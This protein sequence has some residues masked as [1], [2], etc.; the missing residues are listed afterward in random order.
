MN[1][2]A[3]HGSSADFDSFDNE[4]AFGTLHWFT[5]QKDL[6]K[7]GEVGAGT[8]GFIY[9]VLLDIKNPAGWDEYDR[10]GIEELIG[11]GYDGL[12]LP[13]GPQTTFV[14]FSDDQ[15]QIIDKEKMIDEEK[16]DS[17]QLP[18]LNV[19]DELMVGKFKNR[20][21]TIKGFDTEKKTGQPIAKTDKGPQQIFKGRVKKLMPEDLDESLEKAY[22]YEWNTQDASDWFGDF[23]TQSGKKVA[24]S[25][26]IYEYASGTWIVNFDTDNSMSKTG[27]GDQFRIFATVIA[28]IKEFVLEIQPKEVMFV[29]EKDP[30]PKGRTNSRIDL[31]NSFLNRFAKDLGYSFEKQNNGYKITFRMH[32]NEKLDEDINAIE[33]ENIVKPI[34]RR[35]LS[36]R[37]SWETPGSMTGELRK[38]LG[39]IVKNYLRELGIKKT[40]TLIE[41][42]LSTKENMT[43][44]MI[45]NHDYK[46]AM[47]TLNIPR[48]QWKAVKDEKNSFDLWEDLV[49]DIQQIAVHELM[50][51][52]QWVMSKGKMANRTGFLGKRDYENDDKAVYLSD[53]HEISPFAANAV[54][55][56]IHK[57]F[58][59][60][61]IADRINEKEIHYLLANQSSTFNSFFQLFRKNKDSHEHQMVYK[62]FLKKFLQ[63]LNDRL[64]VEQKKLERAKRKG[65]VHP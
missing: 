4:F 53:K 14:A 56:L 30:K 61:K 6:I 13:D 57:D 65:W 60:S 41:I 32:K 49:E 47:F 27:D 20:K 29:A 52:N 2:R 59:L 18:K 19:G 25:I 50:H 35:L 46:R 1:L 21:A 5:D 24:V 23:K 62:R 43:G 10:Y 45:Y 40:D 31:Y 16:E 11:Q 58:S 3:Y 39:D 37:K 63:H 36:R 9:T 54:Q 22:S 42:N 8:K 51:S 44:S 12:A 15:I 33:I 38:G 64:D 17:L 34:V 48:S 7:Q 28:M 55:E 26:S